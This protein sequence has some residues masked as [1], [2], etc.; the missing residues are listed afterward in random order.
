MGSTQIF[1]KW[2]RSQRRCTDEWED[3]RFMHCSCYSKHP[4]SITCS[5]HGTFSTLSDLQLIHPSS[6][7]FPV[8]H[9]R[10]HVALTEPL[11]CLNLA[12]QKTQFPFLI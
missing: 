4:T 7:N 5:E 12:P 11:Y 10:A 8:T 1:V 3:V 9:S 6:P 2:Q